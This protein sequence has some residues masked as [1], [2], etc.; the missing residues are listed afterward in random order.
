MKKETKSGRILSLILALTLALGVMAGC[1][2]EEEVTGTAED[3]G[4]AAVSETAEATETG[5]VSETGVSD[6]AA[7]AAYLALLGSG[8]YEDKY[9]DYEDLSVYFQPGAYKGVEYPAAR[10]IEGTVTD[11]EVEDFITLLVLDRFAE[12][13]S[14]ETLTEG[15][16]QRYDTAVIDYE[17][18]IDGEKKDSAKDEGMELVIGSGTFI[19]G[20]EDG[21]IGAA[22]GDT[23]VLDLHFS[24][25]Y[26]DAEAADKDARFTVTVRSIKRTPIPEVTVEMINSTWNTS[27][28][29]FEAF[30]AAVKSDL[31]EERKENADSAIR[32]YL[33]NKVIAEATT[34]ELPERE[35]QHYRD[36]FDSY[37]QQYAESEGVSLEVFVTDYMHTTREKY[38]EE[39]EKFA[40][41]SVLT[42]LYTFTIAEKEGLDWTEDQVEALVKGSYATLASSFGSMQAYLE[43]YTSV[44]GT[45]YFADTIL[46]QLVN[47]LIFDN[48][49]G[50]VKGG[51]TP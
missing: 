28:E 39:R 37:Y 23:V 41:K 45:R 19:P 34:G 5:T 36:H 46:N 47:Q 44:Y 33:Q 8:K 40:R 10:E 24:P 6:E 12:A 16:V 13:D 31:G 35:M 50:P 43:Y 2:G 21:L 51:E 49:V 48:A 9:Y 4:T 38:E 18:T 20:F 30:R 22:V 42:D 11:Q 3:T 1:S 15:T 17:G 25:Y 29:D 26:G 27:Y 14:T 7:L 32:T